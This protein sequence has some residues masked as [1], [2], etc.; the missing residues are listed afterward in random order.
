MNYAPTPQPPEA[1]PSRIGKYR[2]IRRIGQG[3]A[4]DVYLAQEDASSRLPASYVAIKLL[5]RSRLEA[6]LRQGVPL[7]HPF[8][9][10]VS[11]IVDSAFRRFA[12]EGAAG[13]ALSS[14]SE[15]QAQLRSAH[16]PALL[17]YF[18]TGIFEG[19]PFIVMEYVPGDDLSAHI[20]SR[21]PVRRAD[22][23]LSKRQLECRAVEVARL[24]AFVAE[25]LGLLHDK[26][27]VHR[28]V[29]PENILVFSDPRGEKL[30][31]AK[32]IDLG[33][34]RIPP[35]LLGNCPVTQQAT[36][37]GL[38][39]AAYAAPEQLASP[40]QV[41]DKADVFA[42]AKTLGA[43][44]GEGANLHEMNEPPTS[45]Q[46]LLDLFRDMTEFDPTK[47]PGMREVALRLQ[48][49]ARSHV[50][51]LPQGVASGDADR[52][53]KVQVRFAEAVY[54]WETS[55]RGRF[56]LSVSDL[57]DFIGWS[58]STE[59]TEGEETFL[60]AF[61]LETLRRSGRRVK[62]LF[63]SL[64]AVI[65]GALC[66]SMVAVVQ[67]RQAETALIAK[68]EE[69]ERAIRAE[70]EASAKLR[71]HASQITAILGR[72]GA[73]VHD[74]RHHVEALN[75]TVDGLKADRTTLASSVQSLTTSRTNTDAAYRGCE[76]RK[77]ALDTELEQC[78]S[79][80]RACVTQ[81]TRLEE[82]RAQCERD[83][84][85]TEAQQK[86]CERDLATEAAERASVTKQAERCEAQMERAGRAVD[87]ERERWESCEA[88]VEACEARA[89]SHS[90]PREPG[91]VPGSVWETLER[92]KRGEQ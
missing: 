27:V 1:L 51:S 7:D 25:G 9:Q 87:R 86:R 53:A 69:L 73:S 22:G 71:D 83:G 48:R 68:N 49:V 41:T 31:R 78:E 17:S 57:Q 36:C 91:L 64:L 88:R 39:T 19:E 8:A 58:R 3:S 10:Q 11:Q 47:R 43:V 66:I 92:A 32:V 60:R 2:V 37:F 74:V 50:G 84:K 72:Q 55:G 30:P 15:E 14:S 77:R 34:A 54:A 80:R 44:L 18:E 42:L 81:V 52:A 67:L 90:A 76:N 16:H 89:R 21:Y 65:L 79:T 85:V 35:S 23:S 56:P 40:G 75:R 70:Q 26:G 63:V 28:D 33:I 45:V 29:K 20:R 12:T 6:A 4:G 38:G 5:N 62:G 82:A 61:E 13:I 24:G 59:L 46:S